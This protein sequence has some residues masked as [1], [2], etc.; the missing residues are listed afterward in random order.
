MKQIM[1]DQSRDPVL[2]VADLTITTINI[3]FHKH[4]LFLVLKQYKIFKFTSTN[5]FS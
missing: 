4:L 5:D 2:S 1:C 3:H